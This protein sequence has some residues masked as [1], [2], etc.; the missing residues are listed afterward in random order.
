MSN[1]PEC[2]ESNQRERTYRAAPSQGAAISSFVSHHRAKDG[3]PMGGQSWGSGFAIAW[4]DGALFEGLK[5]VEL[6]TPNGALVEDVIE[7]C[8]DR[9]EFYQDSDFR[10]EYNEEAIVY[11]NRAL[12]A[13]NNRTE[14][15]LAR[16]VEGTHQQ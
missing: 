12:A 10:S 11:L 7:A 2:D 8:I 6:V 3:I 14:E 1:L 13:L 16:S 4:Q 15:R 5:P 9:L